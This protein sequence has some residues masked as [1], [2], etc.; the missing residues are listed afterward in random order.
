MF[1]SR[2]KTLGQTSETSQV[3]PGRNHIGKCT[4]AARRFWPGDYVLKFGGRVIG[5]S[6]IED[7]DW[8]LTIGSGRY[9][10][11]AE[12]GDLADEANH[13]CDP[14]TRMDVLDAAQGL[15]VLTAIKMISPGDEITYDYGATLEPNDPWSLANCQCRSPMC[16]GTISS[17]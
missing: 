2:L 8:V 16:R 1:R 4:V 12:K 9:L 15:A 14:N 5:R 10:G 17:S 7:P 6:E 11:P 13:S 3:R